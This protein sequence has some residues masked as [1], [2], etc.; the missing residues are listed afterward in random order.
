MKAL[1]LDM[2][3]QVIFVSASGF[4]FIFTA[5]I[6]P[7]VKDNSFRFDAGGVRWPSHPFESKEHKDR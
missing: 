4:S 5:V 7:L 2:P 3:V 6:S 1:S